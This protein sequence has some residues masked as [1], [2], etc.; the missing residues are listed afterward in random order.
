MTFPGD[1]PDAHIG[2]AI[3][4]Q[5]STPVRGQEGA[6]M[7]RGQGQVVP[8]IADSPLFLRN[9]LPS[10][11]TMTPGDP[12]DL[13]GQNF[14]G[15]ELTQ[16]YVDPR[17]PYAIRVMQPQ[18]LTQN[19]VDHELSHVYMDQLER[20]GVKFAPVNPK[21]PYDYGGVE[22]L[23]GKQVGD[24]SQEQLGR[25]IQD[26][27]GRVMTMRALAKTGPVPQNELDDYNKWTGS[28]GPIIHQLS[29]L[30]SK[31]QYTA[32]TVPQGS[33]SDL[34]EFGGGI[35]TPKVPS[36]ISVM[37]IPGAAKPAGF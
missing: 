19:V 9:A 7:E 5:L 36:P 18:N 27:R 4:Q 25:I 35:I 8:S 26:H 28:V 31:T 17:Q 15:N 22:G 29:A 3:Q 32:P 14:G 1:I 24:L 12:K 10:Q 21:A 20:Q 11:V 6:T 30:G 33:L 37:P 23:H 16:A 13:Q 2:A 34:P